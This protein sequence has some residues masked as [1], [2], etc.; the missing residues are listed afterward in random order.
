M[1]Y[2]GTTNNLVAVT[3]TAAG[4]KT[5]PSR[6]SATSS[7]RS[8]RPAQTPTPPSSS[9]GRPTQKQYDNSFRGKKCDP[10]QSFYNDCRFAGTKSKKCE[11]KAVYSAWVTGEGGSTCISNTTKEG[12]QMNQKWEDSRTPGD[13]AP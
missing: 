11:E 3:D 8:P 7:G 4:V 1:T 5:P 12:V 10:Y 13:V 6:R 2:D 9:T